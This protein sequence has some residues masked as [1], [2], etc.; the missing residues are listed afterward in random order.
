[1]LTMFTRSVVIVTNPLVLARY[2]IT[3]AR[4]QDVNNAPVQS[5]RL[6]LELI[7]S[8]ARAEILT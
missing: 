5:N 3:I 6:L 8:Y 2:L 7:W 4:A 1:M